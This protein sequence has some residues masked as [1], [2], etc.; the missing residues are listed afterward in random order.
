M[1]TITGCYLVAHDYQHLA[2]TT[3]SSTLYCFR[4]PNNYNYKRVIINVNQSFKVPAGCLLQVQ[5]GA[6]EGGSVVHGSE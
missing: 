6:S 1:A 4:I 2:L 3:T 5:A